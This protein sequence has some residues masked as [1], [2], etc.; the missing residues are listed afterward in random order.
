MKK[1]QNE[2]YADRTLRLVIALIAALAAFNSRG[3]VM[4]VWWMICV[5]A[6]ISGLSGLALPYKLLGVS[7]L[8]KNKQ[9]SIAYVVVVTVII[10][11]AAYAGRS[12]IRQTVIPFGLTIMY[13]HSVDRDFKAQFSST[14][15]TF[16]SLGVTLG[17]P[18]GASCGGMATYFQDFS[19]T[20]PCAKYQQGGKSVVTNDFKVSWEQKSRALENHLLSTGWQKQSYSNNYGPVKSLDGIFGSG[21]YGTGGDNRYIKSVG[22]D[23]CSLDIVY[24]PQISGFPP[25]YIYESCER[26]IKIFGGS[27]SP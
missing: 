8:K 9:A 18:S 15:K 25:F 14:N 7:T 20:V 23:D 5:I 11:G 26:D 10:F 22:K 2:G 4:V 27:Y 1:W 16:A 24:V 13:K 12:W 19:E 21:V 3:G 17:A 6:A